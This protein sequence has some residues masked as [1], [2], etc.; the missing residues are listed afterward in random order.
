MTCFILDWTNVLFFIISAMCLLIQT[1]LWIHKEPWWVGCCSCPAP[2]G[3]RCQLGLWSRKAPSRWEPAK[4]HEQN[5]VV[6]QDINNKF[7][8]ANVMHINRKKFYKKPS[9][10]YGLNWNSP[11]RMQKKWLKLTK[12]CIKVEEKMVF[13]KGFYAILMS[14]YE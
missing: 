3:R 1:Y 9:S 13:Y 10:W 2:W 14:N 8:S 6:N 12:K 7:Y 5:A 4:T 11:K